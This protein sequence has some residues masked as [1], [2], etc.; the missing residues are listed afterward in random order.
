MLW[1]HQME[2]YKVNGALG[3]LPDGHKKQQRGKNTAKAESYGKADY[4]GK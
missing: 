1:V 3:K 2:Q 4:N